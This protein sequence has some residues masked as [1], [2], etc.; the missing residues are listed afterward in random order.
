MTPRVERLRDRLLHSVPSVDINRARLITQAYREAD[1]EPMILIWGRAMGKLFAELPIAV[2]Q[3]ELIVGSPA[4]NP[5][6]AQIFPEVQAGW[7]DEELDTVGS[8]EWDPLV[9][10]DEDKKA[11]REEIL[12]FWRGRT[13][14]DWVYR[15]TPEDTKAV[16]FMDPNV[17]PTKSSALIDN[18]SLIHK[19]IGTVVPNYE[20]VLTAGLKGIM[21]EVN[22]AVEALDLTDPDHAEK[23]LFYESVAMTLDGLRRFAERYADL[24]REMAGREEDPQRKAELNRIAEVCRR[25]PYHPPRNF[26]EAVQ[27]FWFTHLA[28]R[29]E[30]SGHSLS[31]GRFDQYMLPFYENDNQANK[32]A[33]ALELIECLFIKFSE[34]MLFSSTDTSKFYTGVPQ[35]QNLNVGGRNKQG[36]DATNRLSY[37]CLEAMSELQVVQP[38]LS[39]RVHPETPEL[40]LLKACELAAQGT[41]H[42]KFYNEDLIAHSMAG[43]GI[44]LED[45]RCFSIMGCVEPRVTAKEGIHL[46]G[47]FINLPAAVELALNDGVCRR[48]GR[49]VGLK[50][51]DPNGFDSFGRVF[52][53]FKMQLAHLIRHMF[54]VN[55]IAQ[56][57]YANL[58]STPF[59]SALT[60]GCVEKGKDLQHGGAT[61]NFGPSVNGIGIADTVDSFF[62]V[63]RLV[64]EEGRCTLADLTAA[65]ASDFEGYESLRKTLLFD[66]PKFGNDDDD[67]DELAR[68]AV[69]CFNEECMKYKNIFGG[70]AQGG[71]IPVT[72]GIPF[73]KVVGA[74]PSGRKAGEPL[75]DGSSPSHGNDKKGPTAVLRSVA[76]LDLARLRNGDLLNM[77]LSPMAV[78]TKGGLRKFADFIRAFCDVGGWHIQFNVV[79]TKVLRD[80]QEHPERYADLLVRVAGYSAYFTQLHKE[81]QDDIIRR[82]EHCF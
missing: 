6:A 58:I 7:L 53:A 13:I 28:V 33:V 78:R 8:R 26:R 2:H 1:G 29:L 50:T 47:G 45:S 76:K 59:L 19:G 24:A 77:R 60:E 57:A 79:D 71:I 68:A 48:T 74:L 65:L 72:A 52:D 54:V 69:Q 49:L 46:T 17:F 43:K 32:E 39:V 20:K 34:T 14:Y 36:R 64:F 25:V 21:E 75:A 5:R 23:R 70:T 80:A 44:S 38:D 62:A 31:P 55:A 35:W 16:L 73:G 10:T 67:V 30:A 63:K 51:G 18:F 81:V 41:G 66:V 22:G 40:F 3:D 56:I 9:L 27:S 4:V 37:L 11:L 82:T 15:N 61:Y 42:P 12:P